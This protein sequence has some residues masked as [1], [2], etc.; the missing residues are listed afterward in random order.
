MSKIRGRSVYGDCG[1]GFGV[2]SRSHVHLVAHPGKPVWRDLVH[3]MEH[4]GQELEMAESN[5]GVLS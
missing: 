2:A 1:P 4:C 3:L 5:M